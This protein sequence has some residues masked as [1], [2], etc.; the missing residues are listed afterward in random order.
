MEP[1][2][3]DLP[4]SWQTSWTLG[5]RLPWVSVATRKLHVLTSPP[6][7]DH[8]GSRR[9]SHLIR[10]PERSRSVTHQFLSPER[11]RLH[12]RKELFS[13]PGRKC[14]RDTG[15]PALASPPS[16]L[17]RHLP[18]GQGIGVAVAPEVWSSYHAGVGRA[19]LCFIN[20]LS[21]RGVV[22]LK[23]IRSASTENLR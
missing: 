7:A 20:F 4:P 13:G 5:A 9:Q 16:V 18:G 11:W 21:H 10:E 15:N 8:A 12:G 2:S 1:R 3:R 14:S 22:K 17:Q 23:L 6:R 19:C